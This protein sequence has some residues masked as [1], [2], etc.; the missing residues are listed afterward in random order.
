MIL[1]SNEP[2]RA[3]RAIRSQAP[4]L[5]LHLLSPPCPPASESPTLLPAR[6]W[7]A[8]RS[9]YRQNVGRRGVRCTLSTHFVASATTTYTHSTHSPAV[10][11]RVPNSAAPVGQGQ[12]ALHYRREG[13]MPESGAHLAPPALDLADA[14]VSP[15]V[16]DHDWQI[17]VEYVECG[18]HDDGDG[19]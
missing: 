14:Q 15:G 2:T 13:L 16:H 11:G 17:A 3:A 1:I 10:C 18:M 12:P 9:D 5:A 6:T 19:A 7:A 4:L 8:R